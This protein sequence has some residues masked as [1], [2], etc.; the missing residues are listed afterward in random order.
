MLA[1]LASS[2]PAGVRA[3]WG[4][5][6]PI[7]VNSPLLNVPQLP[8][9]DVLSDSLQNTDHCRRH[10][11]VLLKWHRHLLG[12]ENLTLLAVDNLP[13]CGHFHGRPNQRGDASMGRRMEA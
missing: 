6:Y 4:Y 11:P 7:F 3:P 2:G 9:L 13:S 5:L 8:H 10:I 12:S 1:S